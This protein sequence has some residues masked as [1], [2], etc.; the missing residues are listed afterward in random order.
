M[1]AQ[2]ELSPIV[3]NDFV[4]VNS[5]ETSIGA[6]QLQVK[7]PMI[8]HITGINVVKQLSRKGMTEGRK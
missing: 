3:D 7:G 6:V 2:A 1:I 4:R 8:E 5:I